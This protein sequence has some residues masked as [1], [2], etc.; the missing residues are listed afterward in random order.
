[1]FAPNR[2]ITVK[3]QWLLLG[4]IVAILAG[5]VTMYIHGRT[6]DGENESFTI[7]SG[8]LPP[9]VSVK[10]SSRAGSS[11]TVAPPQSLPERTTPPPAETPAPAP[12]PVAESRAPAEERLSAFPVLDEAPPAAPSTIGVAIMGAVNKPGLYMTPKTYR[13]ADLIGLA[14]GATGTADLS[15]IMLTAA[16]IDETTLTVPEKAVHSAG[17][18]HVSLLRGSADVALNPAQYLKRPVSVNL[19]AANLTAR[20][21]NSPSPQGGTT[22]QPLAASDGD[23]INVNLATSEQLQQLPGIGP[24]LASAII[25]ERQREPFASVDDLL[26]VSGIGEK[27]LSAVR[28]LVS[29]P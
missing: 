5:S 3:E 1:M 20:R 15:E 22:P 29:A 10:P 13:V 26:R 23:L 14:G 11:M 28:A 25:A 4:V 6:Q 19:N 9:T 27:R 7:I 24:A 21:G 12:S 18:G 16:L 2:L 8:E 17:A